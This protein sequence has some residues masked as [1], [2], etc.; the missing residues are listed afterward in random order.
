MPAQQA[1]RPV[2]GCLQRLLPR[3]RVPAAAGQEP[4]PLIEPRRDLP[5]RRRR[6]P[7]RGQLQGERNAVEPP[8]DGYGIRGGELVDD[9]V[10]L[11][12]A[13]ALGKELNRI[14]VGQVVDRL[15][16]AARQRQGGNAVDP[17]AVDPQRLA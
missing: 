4:E 7:R 11:V 8:A 12:R 2:N 3:H 5:E 1:K 6:Q 9:E 15:R 14:A 16:V 10:R 13:S 17:F